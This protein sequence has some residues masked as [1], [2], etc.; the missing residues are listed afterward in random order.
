MQTDH[1]L[2][3][4]IMHA[5]EFLGGHD[6]HRAGSNEQQ[7]GECDRGDAWED[8]NQHPPVERETTTGLVVEAAKQGS[9]LTRSGINGDEFASRI[10]QHLLEAPRRNLPPHGKPDELPPTKRG[11][12]GRMVELS[13]LLV[14]EVIKIKRPAQ[15]RQFIGAGRYRKR[16]T[17]LG[18]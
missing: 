4:G 8:E 6:A 14:P 18:L 15:F 12:D 5:R 3:P 17:W 2:P 16:P 1:G 11:R 9:A 7:G 10:G 13:T